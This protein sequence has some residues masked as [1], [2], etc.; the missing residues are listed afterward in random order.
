MAAKANHSYTKQDVEMSSSGQEEG[1]GSEEQPMIDPITG[2][3]TPF[4]DER[5]LKKP[6][7][8]V[9]NMEVD[10]I[11]K[12]PRVS[13]QGREIVTL[14]YDEEESINRIQ[15]FPIQEEPS[16]SKEV[17]HIVSHLVSHS[18]SNSKRTISQIV[19]TEQSSKPAM[20]VKQYTF[21][22]ETSLYDSK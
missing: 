1:K 13:N 11:A 21:D 7:I 17:S 5:S 8:E 4:K 12:K 2:I 6:I 22:A 19:L 15:G 20:D 18:I 16:H 14:E 3:P 10:V 9:T